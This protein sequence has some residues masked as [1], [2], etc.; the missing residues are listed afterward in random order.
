MRPIIPT[1]TAAVCALCAP[2]ATAQTATD[3][4]AIRQTAMDYIE[5]WYT[6]D[7]TRMERA[8]HPELV[9]RILVT[10]AATGASWLDAMGAQKLVQGTRSGYGTRTPAPQRQ[11]DVTLLDA[12]RNAASVKVVASEWIDYLHLSKTDGR[13]VIVH[14]LWE[15]K[16]PPGGG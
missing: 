14:V 4:A 5:G 2:Q 12:F 10:D 9:K 11:M 6:G 8:L 1:I 16:A 15:L 13:W 7:A 3:S